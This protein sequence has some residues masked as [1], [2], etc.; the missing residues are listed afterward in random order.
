VN[1]P[2]DSSPIPPADPPAGSGSR[3]GAAF[4]A[5]LILIS[6]CLYL[7]GDRL[8]PF[9]SQARIQAFV[10]PVAAEAAGKVVKVHIRDNDAVVAG[11]PLFDIDA[12]PYE[13]APL[14][15]MSQ[16]AVLGAWVISE[17]HECRTAARQRSNSKRQ[18]APFAGAAPRRRFAGDA[19]S[20]AGAPANSTWSGAARAG[21]RTS[22][23]VRRLRASAGSIPRNML[24]T[25]PPLMWPAQ[26]G[27]RRNGVR[28]ESAWGPSQSP[29]GVKLH[30]ACQWC[31]FSS[32]GP[33]VAGLFKV[34]AIVVCLVGGIDA[35]RS[36]RG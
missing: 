36:G 35:R 11:Q 12:V 13:I 19:T 30:V 22:T 7:F 20:I 25:I 33:I 1:Q 15:R 34:L 32:E 3:K 8:T 24:R 5:A 21:M 17:P 10:V 18:R 9:T 2:A 4:V 28:C 26:V 31:R 16:P 23:R 6:L 27:H 29:T 14:W